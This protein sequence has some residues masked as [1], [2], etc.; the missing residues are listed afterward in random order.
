MEVGSGKVSALLDSGA[1]VNLV[2][3]DCLWWLDISY[4]IDCRL[5]LIDINGDETV[6]RGIC[7]NMKI[8]IGPVSVMQ[9]L[10]IVK[11]ASQPMVLS[12]PYASATFMIS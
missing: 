1:K 7:E 11:S 3:K 10:L 5:R 8:K 6:L 9:F 2:Q 12:M 4:T